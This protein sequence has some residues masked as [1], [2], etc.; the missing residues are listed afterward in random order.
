MSKI[1]DNYDDYKYGLS[2]IEGYEH[3]GWRGKITIKKPP[4]IENIQ[5][6]TPIDF[7]FTFFEKETRSSSNKGRPL[8]PSKWCVSA[9][10]PFKAGLEE[11]II[12]ENII[13]D[14]GEQEYYR[15]IRFN[16]HLQKKHISDT[17]EK[18]RVT[19]S[20]KNKC[21]LLSSASTW[22]SKSKTGIQ[23]FN[24]KICLQKLLLLISGL[25]QF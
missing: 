13:I 21:A 3:S 5:P 23:L 16:D 2:S 10:V 17:L 19:N 12:T 14:E 8:K 15:N 6:N 7:F 4:K 25:G 18:A 20:Q 11:V 9:D 1:T 24:S 22:E